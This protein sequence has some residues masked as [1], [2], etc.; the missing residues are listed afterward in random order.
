[1]LSW[2]ALDLMAFHPVSLEAKCT[3][4]DMPKS[5]GSIISY[6]DGLLRIALAWIPALWVKAQKPVMGELL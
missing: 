2:V 5:A 3:Y 4:L 6:V 1:M